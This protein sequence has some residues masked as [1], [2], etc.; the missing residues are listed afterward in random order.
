MLGGF[1][2]ATT[3]LAL[4]YPSITT[5][6]NAIAADRAGVTVQSREA[7]AIVNAMS[8]L[9]GQGTW[10]DTDADTYFDLYVWVKNTGAVT[11]PKPSAI[12]IFVHTAGI[13]ERIPHAND[14]AGHPRFTAEV[15]GG[16]TW[17]DGGTLKL[18]VHYGSALTPGDH[19]IEVTTPRGARH[20]QRFEL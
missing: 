11:I 13:G 17:E 2:A 9:D 14:T 18:T 16:G 3:L 4:V 20:L 15:E 5:T 10:Q 19:T 8:E 12:D 6:G 7:I 1:V